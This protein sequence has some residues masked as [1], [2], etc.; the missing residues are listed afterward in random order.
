MFVVGFLLASAGAAYGFWTTSGTGS[1]QAQAVTLLA[2]G[3]GSSTSPTTTSLHISWGA[4]AGLPAGGGYKVLRGT[5]S[6]GPYAALSGGSCAQTSTVT[7]SATSCTDDD[8]VLVPGTTYYYVVEGA[9]DDVATI[10]TSPPSVQFSG[11]TS[12][13]NLSIT[14]T[15]NPSSVTVGGSV[16]DQATF[17]GLVNPATS[18]GTITWKLYATGESNCT[19]TPAFVSSP[20]HV[21]ANTTYT[22][23]SFTTTSVGSFVW[24]FAYT[25][26]TGNTAQSGCGGTSETIAV[27]QAAPTLGTSAS[28]NVNV[29]QSVTDK[30][31]LAG[32][33]HPTGK[34]TYTL[35]GP[36]PPLACATQ[37]GQVK[38]NVTNGNAAY[39]SPPISPARAG[40]YWWIANYGGDTD[41]AATTNSCGASGESSVVNRLTPMITSSARPSSVSVGGSVA[42]Q[43]V[44]SGGYSPTGTITWSLYGN[45]FVRRPGRSSRP[46]PGA[47]CRGTPRIRRPASPRQSPG[48]TH[49]A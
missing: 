16:D 7:S 44:L 23:S 38:A 42:D 5:T 28:T 49:G 9:F 8:P 35:Y 24:A 37:V 31:T 4:A 32:G 13:G 22:S 47:R 30:A 10:W 11:A 6:G 36:S 19:G 21:T 43:S 45:A 17:A 29:G 25:G 34:I 3:A 39:T 15:A 27:H 18:T 33:Y 26:D 1:G 2:P 41:N 46:A 40:T 14:T 20:Q 48:S 12:P